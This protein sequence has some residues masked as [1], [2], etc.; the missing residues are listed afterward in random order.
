MSDRAYLEQALDVARFRSALRHFDADTAKVVR[1][2]RLTPQR[3]LLL[4]MIK[5][6][7][8][9]SESATITSMA[10]RLAM[11]H[12]TLSDLVSRCVDAGL[13][14]KAQDPSDRRSAVLS[15]TAEG[16]QR[17]R[18]AVVELADQRSALRRAL[19]RR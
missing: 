13:V 4:L 1:R 11:P 7:P 16:E 12:N 10:E 3:Y 6:A 9:G 15:L 8:D 18:C 5:G 2:C 19:Q 17:L 14:E